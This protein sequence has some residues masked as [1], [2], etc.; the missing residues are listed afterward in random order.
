MPTRAQV[1]FDAG[2]LTDRELAPDEATHLAQNPCAFGV[3][4]PA[5]RP[6]GMCVKVLRTKAVASPQR[7]DADGVGGQ[8]HGVG[9]GGR[10]GALDCGLPEDLL[11]TLG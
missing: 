11:I 4:G 8:P 9:D 10:R 1:F 6:I 7:D 5:D 3:L 2:A